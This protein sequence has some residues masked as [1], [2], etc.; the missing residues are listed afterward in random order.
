M[1]SIAIGPDSKC[2]SKLLAKCTATPPRQL[3]TPGLMVIR[4][5]HVAASAM[6]SLSTSLKPGFLVKGK[7]CFSLE[8]S[9]TSLFFSSSWLQ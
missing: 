6:L 8:S 9:A 4:L 1:N 5:L 2:I 3:L 7:L